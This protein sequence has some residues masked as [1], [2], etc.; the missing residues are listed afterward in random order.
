MS[1]GKT[2]KLFGISENKQQ[3]LNEKRRDLARSM[4]DSSVC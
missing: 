3:D 1:E 2:K 4:L